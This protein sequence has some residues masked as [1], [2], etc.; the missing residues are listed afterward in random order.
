L[1]RNCCDGGG[2]Y[3]K[4]IIRPLHTMQS[5]L[6]VFAFQKQEK[7]FTTADFTTFANHISYRYTTTPLNSHIKK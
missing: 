5:S 6:V 4:S 1:K 7:D 3:E 2:E